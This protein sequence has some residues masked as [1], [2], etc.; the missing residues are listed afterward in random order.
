MALWKD[1]SVARY[2]GAQGSQVCWFAGWLVCSL[3]VGWL[4]RLADHW[5]GCLVVVLID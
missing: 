1:A 3:L 5:V 2:L 4:A